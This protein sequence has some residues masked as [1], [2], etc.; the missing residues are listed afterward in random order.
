MNKNSIVQLLSFTLFLSLFLVSCFGDNNKKKGCKYTPPI[1]IFAGIDS[2]ENHS[3]SVN[4]QDGM[5][6]I[7]FPKVNMDIELYQSGCDTREQEFRFHIGEAYPLNTPPGDCAMHLA[8]LFYILS[9]QSAQKLGALQQFAEAIKVEAKSF[10]Y[11]EKLQF[12]GSHI[13]AQIDKTHQA[14]SAILTI[15]ISE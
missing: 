12:Q 13:K 3:F 8:N 2:F 5:E 6:R 1:A 4:G 11:N 9:Q 14:E 15:L 7:Y 10:E